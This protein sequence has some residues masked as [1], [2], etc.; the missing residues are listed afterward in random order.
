MIFFSRLIDMLMLIKWLL[1]RSISVQEIE[2]N[3]CYS[4]PCFWRSQSLQIKERGSGKEIISHVPIGISVSVNPVLC[5]LNKYFSRV[6][7]IKTRLSW[8]LLLKR[9]V[10]KVGHRNCQGSQRHWGNF[11]ILLMDSFVSDIYS[12]KFYKFCI[13]K[14]L[15]C[16]MIWGKI[17]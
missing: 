6:L 14:F 16:K 10:K 13:Y 1:V 2:A 15:S 4:F 9:S 5:V 11:L 7:Q 17:R 12:I 3:T 8:G